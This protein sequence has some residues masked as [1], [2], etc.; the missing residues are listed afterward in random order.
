MNTAVI[1]QARMG[2]TRLPGKVMK[3]I[4]GHSILAHDI[5]RIKQANEIKDIII[6]TTIKEEDNLIVNEA[7]IYGAKVYR[8]SEDNVLERYYY[9][10][11]ENNVDTV[12]RITSDCPLIDPRILDKMI[13]EYDNNDYEYMSNQSAKLE[14]RTFPRGLDIE[15][16]S[17][18]LLEDAYFNAKHDY[19]KEHVT[20]YIYENCTNKYHFK[21]GANYSK[22][23]WTLDTQE[24]LEAIRY[25]YSYLY[26]GKHDF[27]MDEVISL[28]IEHP[29]IV[30]INSEIKQKPTVY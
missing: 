13:K 19:Q 2:S 14:E 30:E 21:N 5:M 9:A 20:P 10:A 3:K 29:E 25:I 22:Y 23:R 24:D 18:K 12:I 27:Y 6:A 11:K 7:T 8:G 15:I 16:F 28:M 4:E 26:K 17:F 1:I